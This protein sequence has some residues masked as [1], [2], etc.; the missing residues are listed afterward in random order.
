M[1]NSNLFNLSNSV[2]LERIQEQ[3]IRPKLEQAIESHVYWR[4]FDSGD[5]KVSYIKKTELLNKVL[6]V[7]GV[8]DLDDG[9]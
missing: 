3:G 5:D 1:A 7:L 9:G 6:P 8:N 2:S 4:S